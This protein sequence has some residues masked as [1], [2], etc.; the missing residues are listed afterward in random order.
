MT[1]TTKR[2]PL[3]DLID[4]LRHGGYV[5]EVD[6][7]WKC[8]RCH[9]RVQIDWFEQTAECLG[10]DDLP[11]KDL[12]YSVVVGNIGT[13]IETDNLETARSKYQDYV[14][15]SKEKIGKASG[16]PVYL[17]QN[18]EP[19]ETYEPEGEQQQ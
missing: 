19:L 9:S 18:G 14:A 11:E 16:E 5:D 15:I 3:Y 4:S 8:S 10:C 6:G 12:P 13:V 2:D 1:E 17:L 7:E